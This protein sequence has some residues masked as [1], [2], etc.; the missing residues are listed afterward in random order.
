[1]VDKRRRDARIVAGVLGPLVLVAARAPTGAAGEQGC[2]TKPV[3]LRRLV[4]TA[5]LLISLC[6]GMALGRPTAAH[7]HLFEHP[8][9]LV[10]SETSLRCYVG[11][12]TV[13]DC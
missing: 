8:L 13:W 11:A 12:T 4:R 7:L 9:F 6:S 1:M 2:S 5:R 10:S 3:Q